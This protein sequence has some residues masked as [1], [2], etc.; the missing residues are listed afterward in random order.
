MVMALPILAG[1]V[2]ILCFISAVNYIFQKQKYK[3]ATDDVIKKIPFFEAPST[4]SFF[5]ILWGFVLIAF[6]ALAIGFM[7][8]GINDFSNQKDTVNQYQEDASG[9]IIDDDSE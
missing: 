4:W 1:V 2:L 7:G 8:M 6:I 3:Y 9:Q 5:A